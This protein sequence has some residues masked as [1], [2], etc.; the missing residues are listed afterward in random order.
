M[1][2]S[3]STLMERADTMIETALAIH[4]QA[5]LDEDLVRELDE[6]CAAADRELS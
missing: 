2:E 6:I 4:E 3:A 1:A 5:L